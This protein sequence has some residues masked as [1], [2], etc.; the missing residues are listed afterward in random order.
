MK[1]ALNTITLTLTL[2]WKRKMIGLNRVVGEEVWFSCTWMG[3]CVGSLAAQNFVMIPLFVC[4]FNIIVSEAYVWFHIVF[5]LELGVNG[6]YI[7]CLFYNWLL[8]M[9]Q[10]TC[11]CL[12]LNVI[13]DRC[14][15]TKVFFCLC[16]YYHF[17]LSSSCVQCCHCLW[18]IHFWLPLRFSLTLP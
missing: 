2:F 8:Q 5:Y 7:I 1:V 16:F 9:W 6:K 14:K 13:G 15:G 17:F 10:L 11:F 4:S 18:T 12:H 3:I